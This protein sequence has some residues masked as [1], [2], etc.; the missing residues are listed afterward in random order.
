MADSFVRFVIL[1]RD[2][3]SGKQQ[4]FFQAIAELRDA[5]KLSSDEDSIANMTIAWF[6]EHL[7]TPSRFSRSLRTGAAAT[8]LAWFRSSAQRHINNMR[9]LIPILHAHGRLTRMI[10]TRRP[11]RIVYTD[12]H[13]VIA[14]P[15]RDSGIF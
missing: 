10:T 4:G 11:G 15:Y 3:D 7:A 13:Q 2:S 12:E 1:A 8:G 5:K 6:E 14:V 9:T